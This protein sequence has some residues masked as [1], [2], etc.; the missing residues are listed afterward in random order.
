MTFRCR[1]WLLLLTLAA[2]LAVCLGGDSSHG[3]AG[4]KDIDL[5]E[6]NTNDEQTCSQE[7]TCE[8]RKGEDDD[9]CADKHEKCEKWS[10]RG[11]CDANP[12]YML[13]FC[14][15]SCGICSNLGVNATE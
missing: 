5:P 9:S 3:L 7:G 4:R 8:E 11:E 15:K 1:S 10:S 13:K 14:P 2:S 6:K 12:K